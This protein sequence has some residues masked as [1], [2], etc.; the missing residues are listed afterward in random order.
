MISE[1]YPLL[2]TPHDPLMLL[3]IGCTEGFMVIQA[4]HSLLHRNN[5]SRNLY[6]AAMII[7]VSVTIFDAYF[8]FK[9]YFVMTICYLL[10][11]GIALLF[12]DDPYEIRILIPFVFVAI[13]YSATILAVVIVWNIR[14]GGIENFPPN[15]RMDYL[16]QCVLCIIFSVFLYFICLLRNLDSKDNIKDNL[17]FALLVF[18]ACP[19]LL[20]IIV[21]NLLYLLGGITSEFNFV[22]YK[23]LIAA[24]LLLIALMLFTTS[25][26][27]AKMHEARNHSA[28][29]E[30]LIS[31]QEQYYLSLQE[32]QEKL[33]RLSHDIK[34]H[35]RAIHGL[36][37]QGKYRDAM[38]YSEALIQDTESVTPV[39][40][41]KNVIIGAMLNN[42]FGKIKEEGVKISLCVMVPQVLTIKDSD[43][44]I[45]LG[46]LFD[47][48]VE[49]C[50]NDTENENKFIDVDIRL[51]GP[52]LCINVKNS[53]SGNVKVSSDTYLTTKSDPVSH[54]VG[55]SNVQLVVQKYGGRTIINHSDHVFSV[56]VMMFYPPE[57][58]NEQTSGIMT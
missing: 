54:G 51:K 55:L 23:M 30:Q 38:E 7:Y 26:R 10:I 28:S 19:L 58:E 9:V 27:A 45:I 18:I 36:I 15:L 44:C 2:N 29:L 41:C 14:G 47:N 20:L 35:N 56:T 22:R 53:F 24:M 52:L 11:T 48:A 43:M 12:Y 5:R 6:A 39:T 37:A 42:R 57:G 13:N 33:R 16:S 31:V 21:L 17:P 32:H 49:A 40:E 4:F 50:R 34:N 8:N 25:N 46:N 3:F 1:I